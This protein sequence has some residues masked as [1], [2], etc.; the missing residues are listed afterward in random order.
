MNFFCGK[1]RRH[2]G[3]QADAFIGK[4]F[5]GAAVEGRRGVRTLGLTF[6]IVSVSGKTK[7]ETSGVAFAAAGIKLDQARSATEKKYE[8]TGGQRIERTEMANLAKSGE[9]AN[10]VND[11]VRGFSLR[12]IDDQRAIEGSGL[13]LA[14]HRPGSAVSDQ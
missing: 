3:E 11:V 10:G 1:Y 14:G 2:L 4:F 8:D 5:E 7:T 6:G 13:W 12:L 9:M